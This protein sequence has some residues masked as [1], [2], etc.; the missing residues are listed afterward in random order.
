MSSNIIFCTGG[1][2]SGKSDFALG[3]ANQVPGHKLFVATAEG[4]DPEMSQRI[5]KHQMA[6]GPEWHCLEVTVSKSFRI[7]E[8]LPLALLPPPLADAPASCS[9]V[10]VDCL[11]T[12]VSACH[13]SWN[14]APTKL[15][16][17]LMEAF[18]DFLSTLLTLNK[19]IFVV[20]SEVG[21]GV[22][23]ASAETRQFCDLLGTVNQ[24]MAQAANEVYL[25]VSGLHLKLK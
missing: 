21:M 23:P 13:E 9:A 4:C 11:S 22:L 5:K 20:S 17:G 8:L 2:R 1:N 24:R 10:L 3:L 7:A 25:C 15:E 16:S 19:P 14:G 12:W 18:E 6:R